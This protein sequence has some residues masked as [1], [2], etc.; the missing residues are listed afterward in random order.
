MNDV[1]FKALP[2]DLNHQTVFKQQDWIRSDVDIDEYIDIAV[3]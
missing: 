3:E 1:G 2:L